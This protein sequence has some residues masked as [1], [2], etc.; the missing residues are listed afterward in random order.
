MEWNKFWSENKKEIDKKA[1]RFMAIDATD[2]VPLKI[3]NHTH[4]DSYLTTTYHPK[5]PTLGN[6]AIRIAN[7]VLLE[8]ADVEG[9]VVGEELVLLRW[10]K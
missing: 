7:Q 10:G 9:M 3:T 2:N 1:K 5:D 6:R 8:T 4:S